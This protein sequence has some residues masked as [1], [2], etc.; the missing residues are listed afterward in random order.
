MHNHV[1]LF[2]YTSKVDSIQTEVDSIPTEVNSMDTNLKAFS[3][4]DLVAKIN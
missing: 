2:Q 3:Q 1:K 4:P